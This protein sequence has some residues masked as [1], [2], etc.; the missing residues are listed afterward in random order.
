[1][2]P[3]EIA[4]LLISLQRQQNLKA[5][6]L[7]IPGSSC[8]AA[9]RMA[10]RKQSKLWPNLK[11]LYLG[12]GDEHWLDQI[13]DFKELQI[14]S[15]QEFVPGPRI[16][17]SDVVSKI[18]KCQEL[19]V[20]DVYFREC[21]DIEALLD[22]AH[23]CPLLQMLRV[24]H[25]RLGG[26]LDPMNTKFSDL[27]RALPHLEFLELDLKFRINGAHIQD[28]AVHCPRLTVLRLHETWLCLSIAQMRTVD[29]LR[30]LELVHFKEVLF[31]DPQRLMEPHIFSTLVAEWR[32]IFPKLREMPCHA[33][34][35]GLD[36]KKGDLEEISERDV[37]SLSS[38]EEI[39]LSVLEDTEEYHS[40]E[41]T[42]SDMLT[43]SSDEEISS[44]ESEDVEEEEEEAEAVFPSEQELNY[45]YFGSDWVVLRIKLWRE[46]RYGPSQTAYD[47]FASIWRT[48]LEIEKIGWPVMPLEAYSD[49]ESY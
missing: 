40:S 26:R 34:I 25:R 1:M 48:N 10:R 42:E 32:R 14:L 28:L 20:I 29:P 36:M 16:I 44:D 12:M 11:A 46:L 3:I 22:I 18:G 31:E 45:N 38:Y 15:I 39:P 47:R 30:Q 49:P 13:P 9:I 41:T 35:Y 2:T 19:R 23:G 33:D 21:N 43:L 37:V 27:L 4:E 7:I 17:N 8:S 24:L 6:V 5:L